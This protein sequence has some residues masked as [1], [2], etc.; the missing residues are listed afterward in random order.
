MY[1]LEVVRFITEK[2]GEDGWLGKSG[3]REHIGYMNGRFKTKND[4]CSYYNRHNPHMRQLNAHNTYRSDWDP[5]T[6]LLYIVR[7]DHLIIGD[8]PPFNLEDLPINGVYKRL[9]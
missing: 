2:D 9:K 8:V 5:N 1:V 4:A 6:K 3:K 7:K